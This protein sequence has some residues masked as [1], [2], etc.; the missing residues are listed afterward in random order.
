MCGDEGHKSPELIQY[1]P[2]QIPHEVIK[3][4]GRISLMN[5]FLQF[6]HIQLIFSVL[7]VTIFHSFLVVD[8]I[9]KQ[10]LQLAA[11]I[12][13]TLSLQRTPSLRL[14]LSSLVLQ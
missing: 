3:S 5:G 6:T 10:P 11:T 7:A 13:S 1:F 4:S 2:P 8:G 9:N 12:A 14:L